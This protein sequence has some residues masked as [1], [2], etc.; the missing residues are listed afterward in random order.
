MIT[1]L[2][3][4][5]AQGFCRPTLDV[6]CS[7]YACLHIHGFKVQGNLPL[8]IPSRDYALKRKNH[9]PTIWYRYDLSHR[10]NH[11]YK[12]GIRRENLQP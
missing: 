6:F 9:R 8:A 4:P 11:G 3:A 2:P 7:Y 12:S 5:L 10:I 1:A